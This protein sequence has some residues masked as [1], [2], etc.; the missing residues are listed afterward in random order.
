MKIKKIIAIVIALIIVLG[1]ILTLLNINQKTELK[2]IK[3]ESELE[4][5]YNYGYKSYEGKL[6]YILGL[7]FS[8]MTLGHVGYIE[9]AYTDYTNKGISFDT[10]TN[11]LNET[12]KQSSSNKDYSTTNIQVENVDEADIIKTNGDYIYSISDKNVIITD[13][14]DSNNLK[15]VSKLSESKA[16]PEELIIFEDKLVVISTEITSEVY[17]NSN[18]NT[19]VSIY[20]ISNK[21]KPVQIKTYTMYEPYYTS[22]CINN[23]LYVISSGTLRKEDE[24]IITYYKEEGNQKQIGFDNIKYLTDID[25]RMQTLISYVDLNNINKEVKISSYLIDISNAYVSENAIYLLNQEYESSNNIPPIS[26]LFGLKGAIGPFMWEYENSEGYGYYT[27]IYKFSI[28][29]DGNIEYKSKANVK[30]KTINQYSLDEYNNNLRV[31][32]FNYN[33]GSR[34]V[35]FDE[36]LKQI[37]ATDY[38]AKYENMYSSRFIGNKAYFVTY[39]TMDPLYVLDLSNPSSPEVLGELKIP[40]YSTYLHPYNEN[41]LIGIGMETEENVNRDMNG[42]VT[43]TTARIIG[44][45]MALFDVSD[46]KNPKEI[47]NVVIGDS[48]TTSSILTNPK[49]LLFSKEK[50]IIA[51]PVNNYRTGFSINSSTSVSTEINSYIQRST[52]YIS[53]GYLVYSINTTDGL[54]LKGTVKHDVGTKNSQYYYGYKSKL[55][56]GLY[57]GNELF[58]VSENEIKVN[59]LDTMQEV[60]S[61]KIKGGVN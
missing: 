29:D 20:D 12:V 5:R 18:K 34:V 46:M 48:Y 49:A 42:R 15:I 44:M 40:G 37:G 45:K 26:S 24:K 57:I 7:P 47:S 9:Q 53:E 27:N 10:A 1:T 3:S 30:G 2:S 17:Y 14:K 21:E 55:L 4:K 51:I 23:K 13:A 19:I 61:L 25:S 60:S 16:V 58:T 33:D 32:L 11:S 52:G 54:K 38:V 28:R 6:K 22:R 43:S 56:R 39:R 36:N 8:I 59:K 41:H 31:A 50:G 35:I